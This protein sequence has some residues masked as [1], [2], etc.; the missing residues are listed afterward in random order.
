MPCSLLL[1]P[2]DSAPL[3]LLLK[4]PAQRP[5]PDAPFTMIRQA[6]VSATIRVHSLSS[7]P[8]RYP[9]LNPKFLLR[10]KFQ[11]WMRNPSRNRSRS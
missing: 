8:N 6:T 4:R 10:M 3:V 5:L 1:Y 7:I 9:I 2:S 11:P